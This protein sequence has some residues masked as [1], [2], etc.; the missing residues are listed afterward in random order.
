MDMQLLSSIYT[1]INPEPHPDHTTM[2]IYVAIAVKIRMHKRGTPPRATLVHPHG[3]PTTRPV[4]RARGPTLVGALSSNGSPCLLL[5][6]IY[7]LYLKHQFQLSSR[8]IFL[9]I[10]PHIYFKLIRYTPIDGQTAARH[11][12]DARGQQLW[13]RH[14][15]TVSID[16]QTVARSILTLITFNG[17]TKAVSSR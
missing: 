9:Q 12:P 8:V 1:S 3:T 15:L 17:L 5:P 10:T 13:P 7:I 16:G 14:V 2:T 4:A 11:G 6:Y